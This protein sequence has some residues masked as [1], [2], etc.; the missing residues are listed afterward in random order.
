MD[1]IG[2]AVRAVEEVFRHEIEDTAAD[3]E[4]ASGG[5]E[6]VPRSR[7]IEGRFLEAAGS[8]GLLADAEGGMERD[9][10]DVGVQPV[11]VA[12]EDEF[13]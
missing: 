1:E 9:L 4:V 2:T 12:N 6:G 3:A 10:Q 8:E 11:V 5:G 13:L 7:V